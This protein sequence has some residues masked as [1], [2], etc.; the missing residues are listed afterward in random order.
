MAWRPS[1]P[2]F[3]GPRGPWWGGAAGRAVRRL[4]DLIAAPTEDL[5]RLPI[6]L[7]LRAISLAEGVRAALSTAAIVALNGWLQQ[8]ALMLSALAALFTCFCDP[9]GP[10]RRRVPALFSFAVLGAAV[11]AGFGLARGL[12]I[13]AIP[14]AAFGV[15]CNGFARIY[16]QPAML[17]GNLL[18]VVLVLALDRPLPDLG[19]AA[20]DAGAFLAGSLWAVLLTLVIWRLHPYR[21]ARRAV[22]LVYRALADMAADMRRRGGEAAAWE[23]H[24]RAHRRRVRDSLEAAR[25]VVQDTLRARGGGATLRAAQSLIRLEAAEQMFGALIALSVLLEETPPEPVR[26]AADR[27][28]RRLPPV[29]ITLARSILADSLPP[30]ERLDRSISAIGATA[31]S[32]ALHRIAEAIT[33]R[34][35][36]AVT[37]ATTGLAI[38]GAPIDEAPRSR[39]EMLAGPLRA[40]LNRRSAA[41]RHAARAAVVLVP[42]LAITFA[43]QGQYQHWLTITMVMTLQPFYATTV[44]RALERIGGTVL[45]GMFAAVLATICRTPEAIAA[46]LF[47][48]AM[49]AL[50]VRAA[51]F[52]L[53]MALLTPLVVLLSELGQPG[54]SELQ[55]ALMRALYTA[56]G[57]SLAVLGNLLLWPSWEPERLAG[58]LANAIAAH[59]RY[60]EAELSLLL[61]EA[62]A[63]SVEQARRGAGVA[64]NNLEATLTRALQEPGRERRERVQTVMLVDAALRRMA[65]RLSAIHLD[66]AAPGA[67]S[68]AELAAWRAWITDAMAGLAAPTPALPPERPKLPEG[69]LGERLA[70]IARQIALMEGALARVTGPA[71]AEP[72]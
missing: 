16:G 43:W 47:P 63:A 58:E 46:A 60:A 11:H 25:T 9:G 3:Q 30:L 32:P 65:G 38:P 17:V 7:D 57:G 5:S 53:F 72:A 71:E 10:V 40:N 52:G 61:G 15:F 62:D 55:I 4:R 18:T 2:G 69:P 42:G 39:V 19:A 41:L 66:R 45:G 31:G 56:I 14:L 27:M 8:P 59:A 29:L 26:A 12:G 54:S 68:R 6:A 20:E 50:S 34:L 22:A 23:A 37:L 64:T 21:P 28:L 1:I 36:I 35:R 70:R 49:A 48:L 33:E 13:A 44:Q 24:A 67:E 51:S